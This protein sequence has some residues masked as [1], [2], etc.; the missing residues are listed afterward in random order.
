MNINIY[1]SEGK[2][3]IKSVAGI[4]R[5]DTDKELN[6]IKEGNILNY[7]LNQLTS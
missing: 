2:N 7:V 5:I 4:L 6:Y 3:K 1:D